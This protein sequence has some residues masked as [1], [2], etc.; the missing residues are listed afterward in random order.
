ME[1]DEG[2]EPAVWSQ[3]AEQLGLQG[4]AIP[5]EHGG[6]GY[7]HAE[8]AVVFEEMGA[9]LFGG[10]YFAT[11]A[12]AANALLTSGDD[13][14]MKDLLPGIA[15]GETVATLALAEATGRWD[16]DGVQLEATG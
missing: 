16:A 9:A 14:A 12:M 3:M 6:S 5:E 15:S 11:V 10:P 1:S 7:G 13:A 8:L 2:H 4:L